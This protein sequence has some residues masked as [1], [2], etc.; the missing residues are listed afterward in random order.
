MV[1]SDI[2]NAPAGAEATEPVEP[3]RTL[4]QA[5]A[6]HRQGRLREAE[7][8]Y[9]GILRSHPAHFDALHNLGVIRLQMGEAEPAIGLI[10]QALARNPASVE[11]YNNLGG[12]LQALNRHE[13]AVAPYRQA[14]ALKPDFPDAHNNL[15]AALKSLGRLEEAA[16]E[17]DTAVALAPDRAPFYRNLVDSR[18]I[19][20]D[21]PALAPMEALARRMADIPQG[22]RIQ[23]HFALAKAY[24]A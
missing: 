23:L 9:Y 7:I 24:S 12:A 14:L 4:R 3:Q 17:F 5:A 18:R 15:G 19:T 6:L 13:E 1:A 16:A 2:G 11:A 8:L 21:D 20:A 22:A 10:R